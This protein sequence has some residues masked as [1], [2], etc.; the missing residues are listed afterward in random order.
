MTKEITIK[1]ATER[2]VDCD[3]NAIPQVLIEKAYFEN[4]N[5]ESFR[6]VTPL[7]DGQQVTYDNEVYTIFKTEEYEENV[8][9]TKDGVQMVDVDQ[10]DIEEY[11]NR[12]FLPMWSTMWQTSIMLS[13]WIENN[14]KLVASLGFQIYECDDLDGLILGID[15]AGYDFYTKHWI[16]LYN[17]QGLKWHNKE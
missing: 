16:P 3:L 10:Y 2:M 13:H 9:L 17:A 12:P 14:M 4:D 11:D 8:I 1:Q 5:I 6:N 15:G 7:Y